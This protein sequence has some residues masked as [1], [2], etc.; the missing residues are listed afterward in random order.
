[1]SIADGA[2][3]LI[4]EGM[5]SGPA[6][7]IAK[8]LS[9]TGDLTGLSQKQRAVYDQVIAPHFNI[10]CSTP[11]CTF[12]IDMEWIGDAI[13]AHE[14]GGSYFCE[15]CEYIHRQNGKND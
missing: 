7:G 15:H 10:A 1:M 6:E 3:A 11:D 9:D 2:R 5:L 13:R 12:E 4:E 8:K 14:S